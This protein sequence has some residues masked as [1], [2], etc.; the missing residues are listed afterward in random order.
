[1]GP[2]FTAGENCHAW[3]ETLRG[4]NLGRVGYSGS[5]AADTGVPAERGGYDE[6]RVLRAPMDGVFNS[7]AEIGDRV[8][9]GDEVA[10]VDNQP[11]RAR[12]S[13]FVR[14]M[15]HNGLEVTKGLKAG[16]IDAAAGHSHCFTISDRANAIAGGVLEAVMRLGVVKS[17]GT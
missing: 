4:H 8:E 6:E 10:R 14:G 17:T 3:V 2:G 11:I 7:V 15:L 16:D 5:P 13:G 1:M 9:A 12:I